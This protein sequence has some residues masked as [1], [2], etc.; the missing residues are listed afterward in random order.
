V[1]RRR[2]AAHDLRRSHLR[3]PRKP[4]GATYSLF[5]QADLVEQLVADQKRPVVV[6]A[7]DMGT[8]V[9]TELLARDLNSS[10]WFTIPGVLLLNGSI[11]I[12]RAS[13]TSARR[14]V[15]LAVRAWPGQL[16]LAWGILDPV[17][18]P[19]VLA[20]LREL[21]RSAPVRELHDLG[22]YPQIE[23]P[24]A[25]VEAIEELLAPRKD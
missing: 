18:T 5:D 25:V 24:E 2:S 10:L 7:H 4:R 23:C 8:S 21:R 19:N 12:E 9:A 14:G 3:P 11:I 17:S 22:H 16:R 1:A 6:V 20:G 13:L 15:A